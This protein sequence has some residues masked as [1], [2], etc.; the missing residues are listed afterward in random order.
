MGRWCICINVT[1]TDRGFT[2]FGPSLAGLDAYC[3]TSTQWKLDN[4]DPSTG[5][6]W[7]TTGSVRGEPGPNTLMSW[8]KIEKVGPE[9]DRVYKL[10]FCPSV[11]DSCITL[12]KDI[13][14]YS[15]DG[16]RRLALSPG[17][18]PFMFIKASKAKE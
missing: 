6:W 13:G 9:M 10:T 11:C 17:G 4:Y 15:Y 5:K 2:C 1:G 8:F 3:Q 14:R 12:C 7:I 18:W 16:L